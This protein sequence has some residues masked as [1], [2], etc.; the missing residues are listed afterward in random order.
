[1]EVTWEKVEAN[2]Y[3]CKEKPKKFR[4]ELYYG[5]DDRGK[6]Y[7]EQE[8]DGRQPDRGT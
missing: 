4:V 3:Q 1:M 2:I 6:N 5:R 7:K 8:S